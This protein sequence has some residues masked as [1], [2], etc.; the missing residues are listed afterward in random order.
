[1][2][3]IVMIAPIL[4]LVIYHF[5]LTSVVSGLTMHQAFFGHLITFPAIREPHMSKN[6]S[7]RQPWSVKSNSHMH[8]IYAF[9]ELYREVKFYIL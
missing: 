1:M 8:R 3:V 2:L 4:L 7:C 9:N 5:Y 6:I